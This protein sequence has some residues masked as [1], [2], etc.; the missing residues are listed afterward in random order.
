MAHFAAGVMRGSRYDPQSIQKLSILARL[1]EFHFFCFD[2]VVLY[3]R[4]VAR[5]GDVTSEVAPAGR[6]TK[7]CRLLPPG[8]V[9]S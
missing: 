9:R 6:R 5:V 2:L 8:A 7:S 1:G 3:R 4:V